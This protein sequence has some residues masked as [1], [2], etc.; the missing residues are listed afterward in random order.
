LNIVHRTQLE[1]ARDALV[2]KAL[3]ERRRSPAFVRA[4]DV[5]GHDEIGSRTHAARFLPSQLRT[6]AF[7]ARTK[8]TRCALA[9]GDSGA[10]VTK[11]GT[12]AAHQDRAKTKAG[13]QNRF[14]S[15]CDV[16]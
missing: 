16:P 8:R 4:V 14:D 2:A 13:A 1:M 6:V 10:F 3:R 5:Q 7:V 9:A 15:A 11:A 12:S